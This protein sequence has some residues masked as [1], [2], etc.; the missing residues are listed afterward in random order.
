M[1]A[2]KKLNESIGGWRA[3]SMIHDQPHL[4]TVAEEVREKER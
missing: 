1:P 4:S 3:T 2:A